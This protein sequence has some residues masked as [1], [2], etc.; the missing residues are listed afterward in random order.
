M[1][2]GS[3]D[4][5]RTVVVTL[6]TY[7]AEGR[8]M[9]LFGYAPIDE[10]SLGPHR[11]ELHRTRDGRWGPAFDPAAVQ[12]E[13]WGAVSLR[14]LDC[15]RIEVAYDSS[16]PGFAAATHVMVRLIPRTAASACPEA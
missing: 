7:D 4:G 13:R 9:W 12:R 2:F 14:F 10:S 6:Y 8:Q 5:T 11:V 16:L 1:G 3:I 15:D